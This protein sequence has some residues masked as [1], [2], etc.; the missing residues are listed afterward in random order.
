MRSWLESKR[1]QGKLLGTVLLAAA[2]GTGCG[3]ASSEEE[4]PAVEASEALGAASDSAHSVELERLIAG[5]DGDLKRE[6]HEAFRCDPEPE[7][8][9]VQV[10]GETVPS[11]MRFEW[12]ECTR[13]P[14]H[15]P[16]EGPGQDGQWTPP[17]RPVGQEGQGPRR[18]G[19]P[20]APGE[21]AP[22]SSSGTVEL[23]N[24][25]TVVPEGTCGPETRLDSLQS[26]TFSSTHTGPD[27]RVVTFQ[28]TTTS[29]GNRLVSET[30]FTRTG[31]LDTTRQVKDAEGNVVRGLHL[32]GSL[33]VTFDG[34]GEAPVRILS[35]KFDAALADGTTSVIT[36]EELRRTRGC[37]WPI[38][39]TVTQSQADGTEHVLGFGPECGTATLDGAA[40]ELR[41]GGH[42]GRGGHDGGRPGG[43]GPSTGSR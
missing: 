34:S 7:V 3:G 31:T 13:A 23:V 21:G 43:P 28:G 30:I 2:L 32:S 22:T 29:Q 33:S 39:G 37:R 16:P 14:F 8:T 19:G 5:L 27:G 26:A 24:D 12:T 18:G 1:G 38:A 10:C 11:R 9:E 17:A 36:V 40:Y 6:Q 41:G 25:V 42:H 35:G 15:R 20:H 4:T